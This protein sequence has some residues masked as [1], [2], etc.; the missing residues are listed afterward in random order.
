MKLL[1]DVAQAIA[2]DVRIKFRRADRRVTEHFLDDTQVGAM[3]E[4]MRGE[5]MA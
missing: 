3:L 4:E 1:M 2:G 5:T